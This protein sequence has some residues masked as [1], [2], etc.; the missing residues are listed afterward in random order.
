MVLESGVDVEFDDRR[1][2]DLD[3]VDWF[4]GQLAEPAGWNR[5][6]PG[7]I[8]NRRVERGGKLGARCGSEGACPARDAQS[9]VVVVPTKDKCLRLCE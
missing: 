7:V 6:G 8:R 4:A 3:V 2:R 5:G 9:P 1:W